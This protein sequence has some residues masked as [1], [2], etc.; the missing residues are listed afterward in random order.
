MDWEGI[1]R[2][3]GSMNDV[4]EVCDYEFEVRIVSIVVFF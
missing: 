4:F 2:L 1:I 3:F